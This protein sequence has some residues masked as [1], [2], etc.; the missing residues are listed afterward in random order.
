MR[1]QPDSGCLTQVL[2]RQLSRPS[3]SCE[4]L[5]RQTTALAGWTSE[6]KLHQLK[7]LLDKTAGEVFLFLPEDERSN[8]D[9]ATQSLKKW[10]RTGDIK[11]LRG[12]EFHHRT[13][14]S[15]TVEQLGIDLQRL[16]RKAFPSS[17][18]KEFDRLLKGRFFQALHVKWQRK[19]GTPK[20]QETFRELYDRA[21]TLEQ[22][23]KQYAA[24][25]ASKNDTH[26]SNKRNEQTSQS[27][28]DP[29]GTSTDRQDSG[30][31][32]PLP[33]TSP[34][35]QTDRCRTHPRGRLRGGHRDNQQRRGSRPPQEAPGRSDASRTAVV[36]QVPKLDDFSD[37]QLKAV[38]TKRHLDHEQQLL[39]EASTTSAVSAVEDTKGAVGPTLYLDILIEDVPVRAMFDTGAQS[40]IISHDVLHAI[41]RHLERQGCPLPALR[42]PCTTLFGKDGDKGPEILATA[43]FDATVEADAKTVCATLFVQPDS[44]QPCLLGTNIIP[45]LDVSITRANGEALITSP[46]SEP[47]IARVCLVQATTIPSQK[48]RFVNCQVDNNPFKV[49]CRVACEVKC[50]LFEPACNVVELH[51]LCSYES[52][53]TLNVDG[54][55]LIP[56]ENCQGLPVKSKKGMQLGAVRPCDLPDS[57][58]IDTPEKVESLDDSRCAAVKALPNTPER[59]QQLLQSLELPVDKLSPVELEKLKELLAEST[60]LFALDD[61][62]LGC[63]TLIRHA[64]HTET[65][66]PIKQ[67]LYRTPVIY[68]EKIEQMV[69]QMQ[70]Q[71]IV[72]PSKVPGLVPSCLF[73]K[74]MVVCTFV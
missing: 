23:E 45:Y 44:V 72:R 24:S 70:A 57:V 33:T 8:Y 68:R 56:V 10:F 53:I 29:A 17:Q 46:Q 30:T 9:K 43:Q 67:C 39:L 26:R 71:G 22:H 60:D 20:P 5:L 13:Q 19:L 42:E 15:E 37:E 16:G 11:E 51:G 25:A 2:Y 55:A 35:S 6:Q 18:G 47:T 65:H 52:L 63:T 21:R 49:K 7:L 48:G 27:P 62:E 41:G 61:S 59:F 66:T 54:M 58:K 50:C 4:G 36:G 34:N 14:G 69:S 32:P 1:G 12:L 3:S 28:R 73:R 31:D 40:S 64:I 74:K 38:L